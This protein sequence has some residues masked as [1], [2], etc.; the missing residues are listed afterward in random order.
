MSSSPQRRWLPS[1]GA[2]GSVTRRSVVLQL[3][4]ARS[5]DQ[6]QARGRGRAGFLPSLQ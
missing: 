2:S 5:G 3:V 6:L 1:P 4:L